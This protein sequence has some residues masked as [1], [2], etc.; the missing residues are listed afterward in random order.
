VA[1]SGAWPLPASMSPPPPSLLVQPAASTASV[2][3]T[4]KK[5]LERGRIVDMGRN[6]AQSPL[7]MHGLLPEA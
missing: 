4:L 1:A 2:S 6:V 3:A 5:R 7:Y